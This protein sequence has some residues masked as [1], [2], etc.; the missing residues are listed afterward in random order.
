MIASAKGFNWF[1][2]ALILLSPAI[3]PSISFCQTSDS[4]ARFTSSSSAVQIQLFNGLGVNYVGGFN[5]ATGFRVG[6]DVS[7]HY[8]ESSGPV[9]SKELWGNSFTTDT[10]TSV[11]SESSS[12]Q[13][14]I[15]TLLLYRIFDFSSATLYWG[16]GPTA[17]YQYTKTT[18]TSNARTNYGSPSNYH[19]LNSSDDQHSRTTAIGPMVLLG[20]R[21]R[22]IGNFGI[23]AEIEF[24]AMYKS[25][26]DDG[27]IS[28][29]EMS[30]SYTNP[31]VKETRMSGSYSGWSFTLA[32]IRAGV[33][34][35][36]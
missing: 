3:Y 35:G 24:R 12:H 29:Y 14:S 32:N 30:E 16:I 21:G 8:G 27:I 18:S 28:T 4:I 26:R 7:L 23:T 33:T 11:K 10:N 17:S 15:S 31:N 9:E 22:I 20:I 2:I 1:L 36:L 25:I 6:V 5:A 19:I 34:F 13:I